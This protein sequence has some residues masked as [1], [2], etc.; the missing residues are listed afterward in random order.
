ML[1]SCMYICVCIYICIEYMSV[2][3]TVSV[4][5]GMGRAPVGG[6]LPRG[7]TPE[8]RRRENCRRTCERV[9]RRLV[10]AMYSIIGG[11][12]DDGRG[13]CV[14]TTTCTLRY[15]ITGVPGRTSDHA[16]PSSFNLTSKLIHS[17]STLLHA[18]CDTTWRLAAPR[19]TSSPPYQPW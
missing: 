17:L 11:E 14:D 4:T 8:N 2:H 6:P 1:Y 19:T 9:A 7:G 10:R 13:G 3:T 12:D 15:H 16:P 18:T 5:N